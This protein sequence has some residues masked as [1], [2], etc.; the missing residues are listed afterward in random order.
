[1]AEGQAF[2]IVAEELERATNLDRLQARGTLRIALKAAGLNPK[3]LRMKELRGV[4]ERLL[5]GELLVRGIDDTEAVVARLLAVLP[6]N[7]DPIE[8]ESPLAVFRRLGSR[9]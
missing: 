2:T 1:V 5:P 3:Q 8:D 9:T 7:D 4:I 6:R